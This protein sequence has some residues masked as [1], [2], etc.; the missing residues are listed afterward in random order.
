[1]TMEAT[2]LEATPTP[3]VDPGKPPVEA[4]PPD[5]EQVTDLSATPAPSEDAKPAEP[6]AEA[7]DRLAKAKAAI[8]R[9][10]RQRAQRQKEAEEAARLRTERD[11]LA[12]QAAWERAE[13]ERAEQQ[14]KAAQEAEPLEYL[15]AR[16]I[17]AKTIAQKALEESTPEG[18][19]KALRE[20]MSRRDQQL[21][22]WQRQ[23]SA[24]EAAAAQERA[25][26]D[27]LAQAAKDDYPTL[28]RLA[29]SRPEALVREAN[30]VAEQAARRTGGVYPSFEQILA[31]LEHE[32]SSALRDKTSEDRPASSREKPLTR[33]APAREVQPGAS[34]AKTLTSRSSEKATL[35]KDLGEMSWEEQREVLLRQIRGG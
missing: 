7:V 19:I 6:A 10:K 25:E 1:M 15:R 29:R 4:A 21:A 22:E 2:A 30:A 18:Q 28:A 9:S 8:E 17:D 24:R 26:K 5:I 32:Y 11:Q 20:E 14:V 23:Q 31:Y 34:V 16:G 12:R 33:E 3:T 35:P 27:F 13:R